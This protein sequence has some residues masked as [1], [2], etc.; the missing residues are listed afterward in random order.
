MTRGTEHREANRVPFTADVVVNGA[1]RLKG[2]DLG[3]GGLYVHTGGSFPVGRRVTVTFPLGRREITATASVQ[4]SQSGIGVGL[5]F[6]GLDGADRNAIEQYIAYRLKNPRAAASSKKTVLLLDEDDASRRMTKSKLV[7][8]GLGVIELTDGN[9]AIEVIEEEEPDLIILD[10]FLESADGL[11]LLQNIREAPSL[12]TIP[13]V[14][15]SSK[16]TR[17]VV[18]KAKA[19]GAS[20]FLLKMTTTPVKL[21]QKVKSLLDDG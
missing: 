2:I 15:F 9:G 5:Q 4:H 6:V 11:K 8:E 17:D 21:C 16:G 12:T 19:A 3:I 7:S 20:E 10:A 18:E 14:V 13:I 1:V